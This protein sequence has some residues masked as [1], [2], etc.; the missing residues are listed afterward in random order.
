MTYLAGLITAS[1][2]TAVCFQLGKEFADESGKIE[3]IYFF[4]SAFIA[5]LILVGHATCRTLVNCIKKKSA[6]PL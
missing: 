2:S 4:I 6:M 3:D 5:I 1:S